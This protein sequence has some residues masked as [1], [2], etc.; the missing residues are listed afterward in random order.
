MDNKNQPVCYLSDGSSKD[1]QSV[2]EILCPANTICSH[3]ETA[4]ATPSTD[5]V[6]TGCIPVA[7]CSGTDSSS[8]CYGGGPQDQL[9]SSPLNPRDV[10]CASINTGLGVSLPTTP[11]GF[12]SALLGIVL[13]IAGGISIVLIMISGYKM[14]VSQGEPEKIK[15]AKEQLTA[16][17]IGLLFII[18]SLVILQ[19]I[20]VNILNLPGFGK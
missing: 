10:G 1:Q 2:D 13:S 9:C 19:I 14:M 16:A 8:N 15:D 5:G 18:F 7:G 20:G 6:T 11:G 3:M 17:I 4:S 12:V